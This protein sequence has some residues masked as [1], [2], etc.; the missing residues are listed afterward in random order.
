MSPK[1][2]LPVGDPSPHLMHGSLGQNE[3]T[4]QTVSTM[5]GSVVHT[6]GLCYSC[7]HLTLQALLAMRWSIDLSQLCNRC[8]V[9]S[10][11]KQ[12]TI[13]NK[14]DF[15]VSNSPTINLLELYKLP[16]Y[17]MPSCTDNKYFKTRTF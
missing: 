2:H 6:V 9:V 16:I 4:S 1:V 5:Y 11:I 17:S 3:S 15:A 12:C 10:E 7:P 8:R 14:N 13:N